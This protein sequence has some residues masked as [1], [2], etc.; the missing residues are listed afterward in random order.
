[1]SNKIINF[2]D[3][4]DSHW[5]ENIIILFKSKYNIININKLEDYYYNGIYMKNACHI[6][7]D[8]GDE[9]FYKNMYPVLKKYDIPASLYVSPK[10][11]SNVSNYWFQ[12]IRGCN[13]EHIKK[14]VANYYRIDINLIIKYPSDLI[15]KN[16][17]IDDIWSIINIY[18]EKHGLHM[19]APKNLSIEQLIEIDKDGLVMIGAHTLN[20]PILANEGDERSKNEIVNSINELESVLNHE[21][22][23]FAYPNGI[24]SLDFNR[25][26]INY[27]K[28]KNMRLAFSMEKRNIHK[29]DNVLSVPRYGFTDGSK[30]FIK[31]KLFI[32]KYWNI[33]R[34]IKSDDESS[35]RNE[36]KRK[37][38][39]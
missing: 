25:R 4:T 18:I 29:N 22:K 10:I 36:I 32:G 2:H 9:L 30:Y 3:V 37:V 13:P 15:L 16:C 33:I 31:G 27:V 1:M 6:T 12:V 28:L 7:V 35:L 19:N 21:V 20:H 26:E 14:I 34:Q 24:P 39:F 38:Q 11:C 23:Y 17:R 5:F 8:D